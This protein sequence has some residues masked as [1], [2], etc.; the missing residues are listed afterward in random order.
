MH[1]EVDMKYFVSGC[2]FAAQ[3]PYLNLKIRNYLAASHDLTLL[4]CCV[5]GW[6]VKDYE[7]IMSEGV[8]RDSWKAMPHTAN[9]Q[10]GDEVWS[11][12]HNCSNIIEEMRPGVKVHSLWELIDQDPSF[13]FPDYSGMEVTIQD[14]WRAKERADEQRA[15][16][17]LLGK[18]NIRYV[19]AREHHEKTEFCGATLYRAQIDR[20]PRLAPK[21]YR[22]GAVGKFIPH[23]PEQ[24]KQIMQDHCS[25]YPT[26]TVV[27]YC[28]YCL[29]GLLL[30]GS[31][32][33]HIAHLLF[34]EDV[35]QA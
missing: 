13:P 14:C 8:L 2:M 18:M 21:H 1:P 32:A 27:C 24:Q 26:R 23:T 28:H 35:P 30:G 6:K 22:D 33:H 10:P 31:D 11:L 29:E 3:F 17:S 7:E 16:R 15:V 5:P 25:Q 19:E 4:R 9:F 34:G 12:C 20:N